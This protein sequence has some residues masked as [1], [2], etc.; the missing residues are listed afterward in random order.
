[1]VYHCNRFIVTGLTTKRGRRWQR[2]SDWPRI[3]IQNLRCWA[4]RK[5]SQKYIIVGIV[6]HSRP[7]LGLASFNLRHQRAGWEFSMFGGVGHQLHQFR[8]VCCAFSH[9]GLKEQKLTVKIPE[10]GVDT[11]TLK[12]WSP[13]TR[14]SSQ[15]CFLCL[16]QQRWLVGSKHIW[17]Y[18]LWYFDTEFI[19]NN[20][21]E[22]CCNH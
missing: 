3:E 17:D 18:L 6:L 5:C 13:K 4:G 21:F 10:F 16:L 20:L 15:S 1:M 9:F 12:S 22:P 11:S 19:V 14:G 7:N 2:T 8:F